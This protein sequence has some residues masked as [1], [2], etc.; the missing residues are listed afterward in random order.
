MFEPSLPTLI[1]QV[2]AAAAAAATPYPITYVPDLPLSYH[3]TYSVITIVHEP[4][5]VDSPDPL[6]CRNHC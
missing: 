6:P 2:T 3:V 1:A 4:D 5:V